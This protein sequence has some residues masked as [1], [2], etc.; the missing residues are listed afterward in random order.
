MTYKVKY[1]AGPYSG[2]RRVNA[3]DAEEA[4]ARV[5]ALVRMQMSLVMYSE[6]YKILNRTK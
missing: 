1:Q 5:R 2:V 6:S 3:D 4:I